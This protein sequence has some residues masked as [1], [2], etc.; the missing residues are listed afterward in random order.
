MTSLAAAVLTAV[1]AQAPQPQPPQ[2]DNYN[3]RLAMLIERVERVMEEAARELWDKGGISD[4][5]IRQGDAVFNQFS[6]AF[7][8]VYE[9]YIKGKI[10]W[11]EELERAQNVLKDL[12]KS[13]EVEGGWLVKAAHARLAPRIRTALQGVRLAAPWDACDGSEQ[14]CLDCRIRERMK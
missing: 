4:A 8:V 1:L 14:D 11:T 7:K 13:R 6:Y 9:D 2:G 12:V 5:T 10:G 3:T